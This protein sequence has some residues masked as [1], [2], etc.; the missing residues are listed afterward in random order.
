MDFIQEE[1]SQTTFRS[2]STFIVVNYQGFSFTKKKT[3]VCILQL[4]GYMKASIAFNGTIG[5]NCNS[6]LK[7]SACTI[8]GIIHKKT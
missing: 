8:R 5:C 7:S 4:N 6:Y 1:Q 3:K 2:R